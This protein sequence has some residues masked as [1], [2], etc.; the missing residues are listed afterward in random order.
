MAALV[1]TRATDV[2]TMIRRLSTES[3]IGPAE[4]APARNGKSW[5][6]L[7]APTCS[8]ECVMEYTW[9]GMATTVSWVPMTEMS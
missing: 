4:R 2:H 6:R 3:P 1:S 9:Y 7:I 5:A 8:V